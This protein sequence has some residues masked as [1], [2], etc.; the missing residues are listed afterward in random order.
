MINLLSVKG[1][2]S[3]GKVLFQYY[4]YL[5]MVK[6]REV[7]ADFYISR[8]V[9]ASKDTIYVYSSMTKE[10]SGNNHNARLYLY[11]GL[12]SS[13]KD[14]SSVT[15]TEKAKPLNHLR[16]NPS[17]I[18]FKEMAIFIIG[19]RYGQTQD[20]LSTVEHYDIKSDS[21]HEAPSLNVNKV[22]N[23]ACVLGNRIYVFGCSYED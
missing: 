13:F 5:H 4:P 20:Y 22:L 8:A 7:N 3:G 15:V 17:M 14:S 18:Y 12:T 23:S 19:G 16:V 1:T 10:T 11:S 2:A 21:W 6:K 9:Q